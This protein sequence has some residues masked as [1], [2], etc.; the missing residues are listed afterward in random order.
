MT[1]TRPMTYVKVQRLSL[2]TP[3]SS[4]SSRVELA[5][6]LP[7]SAAVGVRT[8]NLTSFISYDRAPRTSRVCRR[9]TSLRPRSVV[10]NLNCISAR[11]TRGSVL[12]GVRLDRPS[13][14]GLPCVAR[15]ENVCVDSP[16]HVLSCYHR[17]PPRKP[18]TF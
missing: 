9:P 5:A 16:R 18:R 4:V 15:A 1:R 8:V 6:L 2:S 12:P 17:V 13:T 10:R 7:V 3:R 11:V 14:S